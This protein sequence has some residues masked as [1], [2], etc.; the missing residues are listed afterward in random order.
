MMNF[1]N[2]SFFGEKILYTQKKLSAIRADQIC[3]ITWTNLVDETMFL[4]P[5]RRK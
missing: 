2:M 4:A 5:Y 1:I 3:M